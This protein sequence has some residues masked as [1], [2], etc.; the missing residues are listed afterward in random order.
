MRLLR[1][2]SWFL[3]LFGGVFFPVLASELP[4][5]H[6]SSAEIA[7]SPRRIISLMPSLTELIFALHLGDRVVGVSDYCTFPVEVASCTR[8]GAMELNLERIVILRPELILDLEGMHQRYDDS[9]R[10]FGIPVKNYQVRRLAEIPSAA[11]CLAKDLGEPAKG[12]EFAAKWNEELA[13]LVTDI[14]SKKSPRRVYIEVW[15][16]PIQA[17]GPET[18]IDDILSAAGGKNILA[19]SKLPFPVVDSEKIVLGSPE[20]ILLA[21]RT[22]DPGAVARR[23]GWGNLPAVRAGAIRTI[24]PDVFVRPGPRCLA[25]IRE[26]KSIL[27]SFSEAADGKAL[28]P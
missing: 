3:L 1:R 25:A 14:S 2:F 6:A 24:D 16:S 28:A 22:K 18:F 9:F 8:V 13:S 4:S 7:T 5:G 27:A 19:A 21:Y 23:S 26:L 15:D 12:E 10:R 11:I 17:A 20:I